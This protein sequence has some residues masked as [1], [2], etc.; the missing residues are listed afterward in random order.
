MTPIF[1]S[2]L[3]ERLPARAPSAIELADPGSGHALA[4]TSNSGLLFHNDASTTAPAV[5]VRLA[6]ATDAYAER[7]MTCTPFRL[8]RALIPTAKPVLSG[9]R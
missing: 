1:A 3:M 8:T 7:G 6:P 9:I 2:I 4:P 5:T